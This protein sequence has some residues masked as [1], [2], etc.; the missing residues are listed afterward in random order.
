MTVRDFIKWWVNAQRFE[1]STNTI[2]AVLAIAYIQQY[3]VLKDY[4]YNIPM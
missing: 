1:V 2:K 4:D 3:P